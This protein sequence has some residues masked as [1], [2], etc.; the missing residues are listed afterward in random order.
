MDTPSYL[1]F[2]SLAPFCSLPQEA[3]RLTHLTRLRSEERAF[4]LRDQVGEDVFDHQDRLS[5]PKSSC[6]E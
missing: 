3:H 2:I 6:I 5:R 4:R 1:S